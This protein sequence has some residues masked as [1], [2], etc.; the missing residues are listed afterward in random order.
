[1]AEPVL[2]GGMSFDVRRLQSKWEQTDSANNAPSPH[3]LKRANTDKLFRLSHSNTELHSDQANTTA[4]S[5]FSTH[6][7][8]SG[9]SRSVS[10]ADLSQPHWYYLLNQASAQRYHMMA[11][12]AYK[13]NRSSLLDDVDTETEDFPTPVKGGTLT[14]QPPTQ[15]LPNVNSS[16]MSLCA[17]E[18]NPPQHMGESISIFRVSQL[19]K[20]YYLITV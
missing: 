2:L 4:N 3:T 5:C 17:P 10:A 11:P 19:N 7:S 14:N 1:M 12:W 20:I 16:N 18:R 9:F 13:R 6:E 8:V 15:L